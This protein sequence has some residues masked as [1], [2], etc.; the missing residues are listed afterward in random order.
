MQLSDRLTND[1][2]CLKFILLTHEHSDHFD[3]ELIKKLS[4]LPITWVI[5]DFFNKMMIY[6]FGLTEEQIIW[7]QAGQ[8]VNLFGIEIETFN[9]LHWNET[10]THGIDSLSYLID[11]GEIRLLFPGDVRDYDVK[12][13]SSL[14]NVD[15]VFA[16]VWLG[17]GNAQNNFW[18]SY[19]HKFCEF[20]LSFNPHNVYLTHLYD[21]ER[22][23]TDMWTYSHCGMIMDE[24]ISLNP[25]IDIIIPKIGKHVSLNSK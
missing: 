18:E 17:R 2:S 7:V 15:C 24:M 16:H 11:T 1:L 22:P 14:K 20:M 21:T 23:L 19:L 4:N 25:S 5:P 13:L 8:I 3:I 6:S 10:G 12:K 9:G